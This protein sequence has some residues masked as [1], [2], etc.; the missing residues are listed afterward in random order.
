MSSTK[1]YTAAEHQLTQIL[2][3]E[4]LAHQFCSPV[5]WI[6]TQ[7]AIL[8]E[9]ATE[10]LVEIGPAETL[11]NM[12]S[13]TV[14]QD[15]SFQDVALGVQREL[16]S[17]NRD[18]PAIYYDTPGEETA[19]ASVALDAA[20]KKSPI[21]P[22]PTVSPDIVPSPTIDVAV[23]APAPT[24]V[25]VPDRAVSPH[26][27][28][29]TLV[30]LALVKQPSD[31]AQDQTLKALCGGRSTVQNEIIGNLTREF[32]SL[33]D[34]PESVALEDLASTVADHG[35][36]AKLGPFTNALI[37]KMVTSKMPANSNV[38]VLR[39]HLDHRWGFKNGLQDRALLAAIRSPPPA[40][41]KGEKDV[42]SF[43]DEIARTVLGGVGV[44]PASLT[45]SAGPG[46]DQARAMAT[47]TVAVS[48]EALKSFQNERTKHAE[49]LLRVYANQLG[50]DINGTTSEKA[51]AKAT[52]D[53]LQAKLDAWSAEHGDVYEQG[54]RPAFDVK[55]ARKYGSWWNWAVQQVVAL[56]SAALVGQLDDFLVRSRQSLDLISTRAS[57][58]LLQTI[59]W[60]LREL[61]EV[62]ASQAVRRDVAQEWLLDLQ[63]SCK[64]SVACKHPLFRCS[65]VSRVPI[66][67]IDQRGRISVKEAARMAR[68]FEADSAVRCG[69]G[70]D[71]F[72]SDE[73]CSVVDAQS[74]Y[75][76]FTVPTLSISMFESAYRPPGPPGG[77]E[78]PNSSAMDEDGVFLQVPG[79][80]ESPVG[81]GVLN[82]N[83]WTPQLKT[84]GRSGWRTNHVI[85]NGY[86]RWFQQCSTEGISF[87]D[88][89]VL[90]TGAGK[91][92]IGSEVVALCLGAGAKVVLTT[93]SYSQETCAYYR[94]LYHQHGGRGSQLVVVPFNGGSNQDVQKLVRYIY[95]DDAKG[96][97]SGL[98]W[99]LDHIVPFAAVG[100]TGRPIDGIDD[101]SE[102]AHR[103]M[104]TNVVRL[105][106]AVKAAKAERRITT[107]PT[108][109]VLPFSPNHGVFGQDG[110]YAE[111]K[112]ALE[113]LMNKWSSES[114][115]EYLTL[116]GTVI[117][118]TR[119]TGLMNNND[120][121]ATGIE[122]DLG[123][124]TF[125]ASEMAWHIAGLMDA[126][127]ASFC[128]LEPMM[129]DLGGGL[130]SF[131]NLR[132]VLQHI[133]DKINSKS[134]MNKSIFE[135]QLL[136]NG[137]DHPSFSSTNP[138][139]S[140]P[141]RDRLAPKA[142]LQ[143]EKA[144]LPEYQEIQPLA[145]KLR[146]MVDLERVVVVVGFGEVGPYGSS[147]T[148]WEAE[149]SDTFSVAGCV[150]LAWVMGLIRYHSGLLNGKDYCGWFDVE[151]KSPIADA[152]VKAKYEYHI[153]QHSG[154]RIVEQRTHDLTSPDK[155][156]KLHEVAIIQD[157]EPF[158][159]PLEIAEELKR[160][161]GANA[162]VT[163]I[164]GGQCSVVLKA[165]TT[166]WVP[167]AATSRSTIGSQVPT[168]WD[169]KTYG[170]SDDIIGQVDPVTLYA[171][172]AT[173]EAFL[174]A[175]LTDP[176]ELYQYIHV[177]ELGNAV[178]SSMGGLQS[179]DRMYKR[180]FLDR[181]VQSDILAETFVNT[182]AAWINMLLL[183]S[184]GPLRTPVGACATS[185]ESLDTGYDM[186]I[187]GRVKAVLVG[188]TDYLERELA[189]EFANMQATIH[190]GDNAAA[191]R[192]AKEASRPATT[193]RAGFVEGEGCGVQLL[194]TA[195]L[196][197]DMGLPIRAIVALTHMAS[198][199]IGRSVP[200]P[201]KGIL[202]IA[203]E[204]PSAEL[205]ASPLLD[206][207]HRRR[208][209]AIRLRQIDEQREAELARVNSWLQQQQ[210]LQQ[211][212]QQQQLQQ[213]QQQQ[214]EHGQHK[215]SLSRSTS[216]EKH[217]EYCR[218]EIDRDAKR[219]RQVAKNTYGNDFWKHDE[220]ISP[221][222][223]A[224]AVWGLTVNDL[225][226]ASLHGTSTKLNDVN[227][228]AVVQAQLASLGR[229][230]GNV[231]PCCLQKGLVGHG[232]GAAGALAVNSCLQMLASGVIPGNR[233]ADD[234]D[235]ALQQR[236]LLFF[237]SRTY[238][239]PMG[240][241]AFS[242]T[243]FGFGQKGAQVIGV[244]ARYLFAT[245]SQ[246]E[247]ESYRVRVTEREAAAD[248]ALQQGIYGG[249]LV[250]VKEHNVYDKA[251]L[252]EA[253]LY[254]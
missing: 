35:A 247:Y 3:T 102:L 140:P 243:S 226:V 234:I 63:R 170:I 121:L 174:S 197:L 39:Q 138:T 15:Y 80:I 94:D 36:G 108:H 149:C 254:R 181:Q 12:A 59:D 56:F 158:E 250:N 18:A 129:A 233:N 62:P 206:V 30:A 17:Y 134:D 166:L 143:V 92:S 175:G 156:P 22:A 201:G 160:E 2:L 107:H 222:R 26:D 46:G 117:G 244:N 167:K 50:R 144:S 84:K 1:D 37:N 182:T 8:G 79:T 123:I 202:T 242:V 128:D 67:E 185:L 227:E 189:R 154:I 48:S 208:R 192:T 162:A 188:G 171:L 69:P 93:S 5:Q 90:V 99:D 193:T 55:K 217:A 232:K 87:A 221:L 152:E 43:L 6:K 169:P 251:K 204:K 23:T 33:P 240:V 106:G 27:I 145:A 105:L 38:T 215:T 61:R 238:Q 151:T 157:L 126:S 101:K 34:Q 70:C 211:Q 187:N 11:T 190:A 132:P 172:V 163:E 110:L 28:I 216:A 203:A 81:G 183:G 4:L 51:E 146:D 74:Y 115:S 32:G 54:I 64:D 78:S 40:R 213:Q 10:R 241:K 29:T 89:T 245:L 47:A 214:Q 148:R 199:G 114:W 210:L 73:T 131:I 194:M 118:W 173:V 124:R 25:S 44:D 235:P 13:K 53:Q 223:G 31:I 218:T 219:A 72:D 119:G 68:P 180:R 220:S 153:T 165:G 141:S 125:S 21:T 133:Q 150:E 239:N 91:A 116:C 42:H 196:A 177:S 186:V 224:L 95:D 253:M 52:I 142:R 112:L 96:G 159:V 97:L 113:A 16:L 184:S 161:H 49:D 179:L 41:L 209:L 103:V 76:S 83:T 19:A 200:S 236:D 205:V 58:R 130:S 75:G 45:T 122:A 20:V 66:L 86:L 176:Y 100:E 77:A 164:D 225:G 109:V 229:T 139:P 88:K 136:E 65:V 147:R 207:N 249:K 71:T 24:I 14:N 111:S 60:L 237:P 85:T 82:N 212:Q 168:G 127:T 228:T 7:D 155:E 104:L 98:G 231:L 57:P 135:E 191:G 137:E 246:G 198:D 178:G 195:R 252:E 9:F 248:K 230:P 120:L